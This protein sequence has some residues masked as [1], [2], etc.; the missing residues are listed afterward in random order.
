MSNLYALIASDLRQV[1]GLLKRKMANLRTAWDEFA[2][3]HDALFGVVADD[4]VAEELVVFH[5]QLQLYNEALCKA[6]VF[7]AGYDEPIAVPPSLES[8]LVS[9]DN[10]LEGELAS[11]DD[12]LEGE[13]ASRDD[14]L[15]SKLASRDDAPEGELASRDDAL[16]GEM[17]S[18]TKA[19]ETA[20][21]TERAP[22][23][24]TKD[25][26]SSVGN[27]ALEEV[28]DPKRGHSGKRGH[29]DEASQGHLAKA[30][31]TEA[32]ETAEATKDVVSKASEGNSS[33]TTWA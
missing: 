27:K 32:S 28:P 29:P 23:K 20:K 16:E 7:E 30:S 19:L 5:A 13:L 10:A 25:A 18:S 17:A 11:R 2:N 21:A 8:E 9:R 22:A 31:S 26:V 14:A 1:Q 15:G 33:P 12:A 6:T 3:A 24:A 4:K